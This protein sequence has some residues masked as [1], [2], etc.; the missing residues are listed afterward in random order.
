MDADST[1]CPYCAE[2][3]KK[4]AILCKHCGSDLTKPKAAQ[5]SS[6]AAMTR[7][8]GPAGAALASAAGA[9]GDSKA[10]EA[11]GDGPVRVIYEGAGSQMQNAF[12]FAM[13]GAG[14]ALGVAALF[15]PSAWPVGLALML[16]ALGLA[17]KRY[18][19]VAFK[20]YKVTDAKVSIERGILIRS[21]E[22]VLL[23]RVKDVTFEQNL[24]ERI[25]GY[26]HVTVLSADATAPVLVL[27]GVGEAKRIY[28]E[29]LGEVEKISKRHGVVHY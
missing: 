2:T 15:L 14:F 6:A 25:L 27:R 26:G 10:A 20:R 12:A 23:V 1:T 11:G 17:A 24:L 28:N 19:D 7:D 8:E 18:L 21:M 29:L 16:F 5:A 3:I 4:A 9:T 13:C 22:H